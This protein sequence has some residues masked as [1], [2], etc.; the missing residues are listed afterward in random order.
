MSTV[1]RTKRTEKVPVHRILREVYR[2]YYEFEEYVSH[3]GNHVIDY[4]YPVY[5]EIV[6]VDDDGNE[7]VVPGELKDRVP[8]SISFFDLREAI[9]DPTVLSERKRQA[10]LLNVIRD[11]KQKDVAKLMG[12]TTVSVGQYVEQAMLQLAEDQFAEMLQD[13]SQAAGGA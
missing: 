5:E 2:H 6:S 12:I 9:E 4:A 1:Q 10:V 3:T 11:M 7:V 13:E 8:I